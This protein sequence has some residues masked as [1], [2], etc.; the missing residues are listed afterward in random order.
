MKRRSK[1]LLLLTVFTTLTIALSGCSGDKGS[2]STSQ[3][4]IGI[5]QDIEDSLD[6]HKVVAAGTKE[7]FFKIYEGIVKPDSD[8]NF[9]WQTE[10]GI[11][12]PI[13]SIENEALI[14]K[15]G[16]QVKYSKAAALPEIVSGAVVDLEL[17]DD[18][19]YFTVECQ[20]V[21][22]DAYGDELFSL[23][24][25]NNT[26]S[27]SAPLFKEKTQDGVILSENRNEIMIKR[28]DGSA[29]ELKGTDKIENWPVLPNWF[30]PTTTALNEVIISDVAQVEIEGCNRISWQ[31]P[32]AGRQ[33][34]PLI[35]RSI[36]AG[37]SAD[38]AISFFAKEPVSSS[39]VTELLVYG[40]TAAMWGDYD[41]NYNGNVGNSG[42]NVW[43]TED[44]NWIWS[45]DNNDVGNGDLIWYDGEAFGIDDGTG[46][47]TNS[48][49]SSLVYQKHHGS[50]YPNR[51]K[52]FTFK[53]TFDRE[54]NLISNN[55]IYYISD[56]P[57]EEVVV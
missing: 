9:I 26:I 39:K 31:A 28:N 34:H 54:L 48:Y 19:E 4:T 14:I 22:S 56:K 32:L 11:K 6:P 13:A 30:P 37:K 57:K 17:N 7:I 55:S 43:G 50:Q 47:A 45:D 44:F 18:G 24:A 20:H 41:K 1:T 16:N 51:N 5:A 25:G 29:T 53:L 8:G 35:L 15:S 21:L 3:I 49:H 33:N 10:N 38:Y 2:D 36:I 46:E 23:T 12:V 52:I 42:I 27:I 40:D